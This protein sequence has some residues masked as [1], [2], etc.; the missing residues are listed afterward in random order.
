MKILE[1][2]QWC[3]FGVF[4]VNCENVLHFILIADFE[5]GNVCWV[6]IEKTNTIE[7]KIENIMRYVVVF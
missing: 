6:H 3:R 2:R 1:W 4:I 7:D 5:Q